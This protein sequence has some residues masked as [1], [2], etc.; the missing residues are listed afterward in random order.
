M[1]GVCTVHCHKRVCNVA[2]KISMSQWNSYTVCD[3]YCVYA[4][5]DVCARDSNSAKRSVPSDWKRFRRLCRVL[6]FERLV[7]Y[8]SLSVFAVLWCT[9]FSIYNTQWAQD[10]L[11][12]CCS[13][14]YETLFYFISI[15]LYTKSVKTVCVWR[16][17]WTDVFSFCRNEIHTFR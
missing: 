15:H 12:G 10:S 5:T 3:A 11:D 4:P 17:A 6:P 16:W 2:P 9:L 14:V 1:F 7:L 8:V 13:C